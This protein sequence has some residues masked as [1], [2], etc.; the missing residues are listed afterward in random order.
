MEKARTRGDCQAPRRGVTKYTTKTTATRESRRPRD[1]ITSLTVGTKGT[2]EDR[3]RR[4]DKVS[5]SSNPACVKILVVNFKKQRNACMRC[6]HKVERI[7]LAEKDNRIVEKTRRL[8]T[9]K[10]ELLP[11]KPLLVVPLMIQHARKAMS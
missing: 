7:D 5:I 3:A 9:E 2:R 8:I 4:P 11:P 6:T 10:R 1:D